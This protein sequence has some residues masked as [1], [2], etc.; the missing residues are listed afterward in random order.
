MRN[1]LHGWQLIHVRLV[2]RAGT[3]AYR[4]FGRDERW[5]VRDQVM[6]AFTRRDMTMSLI[7]RLSL[8][9]RHDPKF[10]YSTS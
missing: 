8:S 9:R 1:D 7:R 2:D 6:N 5:A 3:D 10:N 4:A